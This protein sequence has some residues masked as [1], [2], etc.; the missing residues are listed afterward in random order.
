[1]LLTLS[2]FGIGFFAKGF[3][4]K[5]L[6]YINEIGGERFKAWSIIVIFAIWGLST[7]ISA[8]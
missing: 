5:I 1:L 2:Y 8:M 3:F 4:G 6:I 7:L